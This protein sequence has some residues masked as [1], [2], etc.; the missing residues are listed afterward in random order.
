MTKFRI[1]IAATLMV[2]S[3]ICAVAKPRPPKSVL[4]KCET[5]YINT[6]DNCDEVLPSVCEEE[7]SN[8]YKRCMARA[9]YPVGAS[10]NPPPKLPSPPPIKSPTPKPTPP[11]RGPTPPPKKQGNPSPTATPPTTTIYAKPKA[12][13][14]PHKDHKP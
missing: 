8:A 12:T 1:S 5:V 14:S 9:G 3:V 7:A 10:T 11:R 6:F 4:T 13:P 2:A